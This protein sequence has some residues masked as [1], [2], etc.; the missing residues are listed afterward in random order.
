VLAITSPKLVIVRF[1]GRNYKTWY[2]KGGTSAD[3][4]DYNYSA[5]ELSPWMRRLRDVE[6]KVEEM[7]LLMNTNAGSQGPDNAR[8]LASVMGVKLPGVGR[9]YQG[10]ALPG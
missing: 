10:S 1:H 9:S 5:D 2:Q 8:L 4:F 7:H 3:R 6:G